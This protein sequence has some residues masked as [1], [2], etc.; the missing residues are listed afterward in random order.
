VLHEDVAERDTAADALAKELE[1]QRER[2][3]ALTGALE[4]RTGEWKTAQRWATELSNRL[5]ETRT[6]LAEEREL[7]GQM[8]VEVERME[9][10]V[11]FYCIWEY[12]NSHG[13]ELFQFY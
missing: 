10:R 3:S 6:E 1:G 11:M 9:V 12:T 2:V 5:D 4:S 8:S 13:W 7:A